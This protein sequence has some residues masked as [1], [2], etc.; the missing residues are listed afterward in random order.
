MSYDPGAEGYNPM[1]QGG[2][3]PGAE[4]YDP[5]QQGGYNPGAEGYDPMQQGGY[6]PMQQGAIPEDYPVDGMPGMGGGAGDAVGSAFSGVDSFLSMVPELVISGVIVVITVSFLKF[7]N[8]NAGQS[9][10]NLLGAFADGLA[11]LADNANTYAHWYLWLNIADTGVAAIGAIA[12]IF[13]GWAMHN[14]IDKYTKMA[15]KFTDK[16]TDGMPG[17]GGGAN[18]EA[19]D[20]AKDKARDWLIQGKGTIPDPVG[21]PSSD[22]IDK[23]IQDVKKSFPNISDERIESNFIDM[24]RTR[25]QW[26]E[27]ETDRYERR[28]YMKKLVAKFQYFQKI[29]EESDHLQMDLKTKMSVYM[30]YNALQKLD[31]ADHWSK[32]THE[33]FNRILDTIANMCPTCGVGPKTTLLD[34]TGYP[35]LV[36]TQVLPAWNFNGHI[37]N[38]Q[39]P[40]SYSVLSSRK[41]DQFRQL[42]DT[43]EAVCGGTGPC[44]RALHVRANRFAE[45]TMRARFLCAQESFAIFSKKGSTLHVAHP[46]KRYKRCGYLSRPCPDG[47]RRAGR[48]KTSGFHLSEPLNKLSEAWFAAGMV[49]VTI[50]GLNSNRCGA[51]E[52]F[53]ML[54]PH[55]IGDI[56]QHM[57]YV[58]SLLSL[59][60]DWPAPPHPCNTSLE[61]KGNSANY[62]SSMGIWSPPAEPMALIAR[63]QAASIHAIPAFPAIDHFDNIVGQADGM[64][65]A[66]LPAVFQ[67][68]GSDVSSTISTTVIPMAFHGEKA[69]LEKLKVPVP[70]LSNQPPIAAVGLDFIRCATVASVVQIPFY[71]LAYKWTDATWKTYCTTLEQVEKQW[72]LESIIEAHGL[73]GDRTTQLANAQLFLDACTHE[74]GVF[75]YKEGASKTRPQKAVVF[76]TEPFL[77]AGYYAGLARF[78]AITGL[79]PNADN[80]AKHAHMDD[81]VTFQASSYGP[82]WTTPV[83]YQCMT[84]NASPVITWPDDCPGTEQVKTLGLIKPPSN[85]ADWTQKR[86]DV[87]IH[88]PVNPNDVNSMFVARTFDDLNS[89]TAH[90]WRRNLIRAGEA[91]KVCYLNGGNHTGCRDPTAA[92]QYVNGALPRSESVI[93]GY[94]LAKLYNPWFKIKGA[95]SNGP[96]N[97]QQHIGTYGNPAI[98]LHTKLLNIDREGYDRMPTSPELLID[99]LATW[100]ARLLQAKQRLNNSTMCSSGVPKRYEG[101]TVSEYLVLYAADMK[102]LPIDTKQEAALIGKI[103][104]TVFKPLLDDP[105]FNGGQATTSYAPTW[106]WGTDLTDLNTPLMS[107]VG[108]AIMLGQCNP[109]VDAKKTSW[110]Q[111]GFPNPS[112]PN[113]T[114]KANAQLP[115]RGGFLNGQIIDHAFT[116]D[117]SFRGVMYELGTISI[118]HEQNDQYLLNKKIMPFPTPAPDGTTLRRPECRSDWKA[119]SASQAPIT[120]WDVGIVRKKQ[121]PMEGERNPILSSPYAMGGILPET[122]AS[123]YC[124]VAPVVCSILFQG[125]DPTLKQLG[126]EALYRY[127]SHVPPLRVHSGDVTMATS[128]ASTDNIGANASLQM[129]TNVTLQDIYANQAIYLTQTTESPPLTDAQGD[130]AAMKTIR[131]LVGKYSEGK[132]P[133]VRVSTNRAY[134]MNRAYDTDITE[135]EV[136]Q[137]TAATTLSFGDNNPEGFVGVGP[138]TKT[139]VSPGDTAGPERKVVPKNILA[140]SGAF[141]AE[142]GPYDTG[143]TQLGVGPWVSQ[144]SGATASSSGLYAQVT[145][146]TLE[147]YVSATQRLG[148]IAVGNDLEMSHGPQRHARAGDAS[149]SGASQS[150]IFFGK[151]RE[152][153]YMGELPATAESSLDMINNGDV[154]PDGH[155]WLAAP[156]IPI[157]EFLETGKPPPD[158]KGRSGLVPAFEGR[159]FTS[160]DLTRQAALI[161]T[162]APDVLTHMSLVVGSAPGVMQTKAGIMFASFPG[163]TDDV[164]GVSNIPAFSLSRANPLSAYTVDG[165]NP[166]LVTKSEL[167]LIANGSICQ[168]KIAKN[169]MMYQVRKDDLAAM[170]NSSIMA[171]HLDDASIQLLNG[172]KVGSNIKLTGPRAYHTTCGVVR[173][174]G[175]PVLSDSCPQRNT[176]AG[177]VLEGEPPVGAPSEPLQSI[178]Y[179]QPSSVRGEDVGVTTAI[180]IFAGNPE[181]NAYLINGPQP[182]IL[183]HEIMENMFTTGRPRGLTQQVTPAKDATK[184]KN[185]ELRQDL[186]YLVTKL[187][188]EKRNLNNCQLGSTEG[189]AVKAFVTGGSMYQ[190]QRLV[191]LVVTDPRVR[192]NPLSK[193]TQNNED[194]DRFDPEGHL[195]FPAAE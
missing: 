160:I 140:Q 169:A 75:Q 60:A 126:L 12:S 148:Q 40:F 63:R 116:C 100:D 71:A 27:N 151:L 95:I 117:A 132:L 182:D 143:G 52:V 112:T 120:L 195:Y 64:H 39:L 9:F 165:V 17:N 161:D 44:L 146:Q 26:S 176:A 88:K 4:G 149:A 36:L 16:Y 43:K 184:A 48:V 133:D 78:R 53:C 38:Y 103:G 99:R 62:Q 67:M 1:Q 183:P 134:E 20:V 98:N 33:E 106:T 97:L 130:C 128:H 65:A 178:A 96:S 49:D 6:D 150:Q 59:R 42:H 187:P 162:T 85:V 45:L 101:K 138:Q 124:S 139:S 57:D 180:R 51:G 163:V 79:E 35:P 166:K 114:S 188:I 74:V 56:E 174:D 157:L 23:L 89:T 30:T 32:M 54:P 173:T 175:T 137:R 181:A 34:A 153:Q 171:F 105:R 87:L 29:S 13:S 102:M 172:T 156:I 170:M 70:G 61:V 84:D 159:G 164:K 168:T 190:N 5:M 185:T 7:M 158:V 41:T 192:G 193:A 15:T 28:E 46:H 107:F 131:K 92:S 121:P 118:T 24:R 179:S 122:F 90:T 94:V 189:E 111:A 86:F 194:P 177:L 119:D 19:T 115:E 135:I 93:Y 91:Q 141:F 25:R 110:T 80:L 82:R 66:H 22:V 145:T 167:T 81:W 109:V 77:L 8:G 125:N 47:L 58:A 72:Y 83:P 55:G 129:H 191:D 147:S 69:R 31:D 37:Q 76:A 113:R 127:L 155:A 18:G 186:R 68:F 152:Q 144:A 136:S 10:Q 123:G 11:G 50:S 73:Q 3:N 21:T 154:G 14:K 108:A 2:Y 104:A 142:K